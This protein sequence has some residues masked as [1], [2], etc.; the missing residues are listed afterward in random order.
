[1]AG[2]RGRCLSFN[3]WKLRTLKDDPPAKEQR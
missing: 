2:A 1:M 3:A